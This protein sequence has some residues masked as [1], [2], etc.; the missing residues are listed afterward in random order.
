MDKPSCLFIRTTMGKY[1]EEGEKYSDSLDI[2]LK[3]KIK[4][5]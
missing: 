5:V 4:D 1:S 3:H 2:V